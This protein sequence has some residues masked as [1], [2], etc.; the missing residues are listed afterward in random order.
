MKYIFSFFLA[1]SLIACAAG[2]GTGPYTQVKLYTNLY[3]QTSNFDRTSAQID[4]TVRRSFVTNIV[5]LN[6]YR[7]EKRSWWGID[8]Y[9]RASRQAPV[10]ES[11]FKVLRYE[12]NMANAQTSFSHVG[13]KFHWRPS[14][15]NENLWFKFILLAPLGGST[16]ATSNIPAL[17]NSGFQFWSQVNYN[18]KLADGLYGYGELSFVSRF[19]RDATPTSDFFVPIKAFLSYFPIQGFGIFGFVDFTP[20]ISSPTAFYFQ[21]GGGVKFFPSQL[22]EIELSSS[23]FLAGKSSGAGY[24]FNLGLSYKIQAMDDQR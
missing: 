22:W 15:D 13:P 21:A 7:P 8:A 17:D 20:T 19:G 2:Q 11:P 1:V 5:E 18:T 12:N 4:D 10:D 3:S 16:V 14:E 23:S 24:N 6:F 9:F